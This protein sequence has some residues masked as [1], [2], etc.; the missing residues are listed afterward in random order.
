V[1]PFDAD[2]GERLRRLRRL[3][4]L[5]LAAL[6]GRIGMSYQQLQK[7]ERGKNTLSVRRASQLAD[8]LEVPVACLVAPQEP[9]PE[10]DRRLYVLGRLFSGLDDSRKGMLLGCA[11]AIADNRPDSGTTQ[12]EVCTK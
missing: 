5:S 11:R 2:L 12:E 7:Y 9:E 3:R 10:V 8:A 4:G 1:T 6:G